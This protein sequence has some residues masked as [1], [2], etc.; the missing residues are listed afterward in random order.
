MIPNILDSNIILGIDLLPMSKSEEF[1]ALLFEVSNEDR[2]KI[3]C[4]LHEQKKRVSDISR[5]L[6]LTYTEIRRHISRLQKIDL[7][8]RDL[9]GFYQLTPYGETCLKLFDDFDFL[10]SHRDYFASHTAVN[11]P[12]RFLKRLSELSLYQFVDNFME[13]LNFIDEKIKESKEFVWL[14]IDRYPII[15]VDSLLDSVERGVKIRINEQSDLSGPSVAFE[16]KHLIALGSENPDVIIKVHDRKDVYLFISDAGSAISFPNEDGFDYSG[17]T[18]TDRESSNWGEDLFNLYWEN[19]Q[20]KM[21]VLLKQFTTVTKKKGKTITVTAKTDPVLNSHAIQN[22]VDNF[23]EV[24]LRGTFNLEDTGMRNAA[25]GTGTTVIKIRKSV[26]IRGEGREKDVPATKINKNTWKFPFVDLEYVFEVD[27]EDIDVTIENIHFQDFNCACVTASRGNSVKIC[28]NRITLPSGLGR[29]QSFPNIGNIITG[30]HIMNPISDKGQFPGGVLIE[31]N[32][33]DFALNYI[34][35][36]YLPRTKLLDPEYRPDLEKHESYLG[37]GILIHN[38]LGKVVISNN[39]VRN[40]NTR[41]IV[42]Q[43]NYESSSI[44]ITGNT[45]SSEIFGS[46][47]YSTHFAG[48]GIQAVSAFE[49]ARSGS[50]VYISDNDIRCSKLNYCSIAVYGPSNYKDLSGKLGEC[51]INNNRIHL[52][53]GSVGIVIRKNDD[54]EVYD[55]RISGSVYY[56]F[57]LWGSKEREGFDLGSNDNSIRDNDLSSLIIKDSDE[58]SDRHVDGRMFTG[59]DGNSKTAHVWL[60]KYSNRNK[61]QIRDDEV[62]IDEGIDNEIIREN[63]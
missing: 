57:Q 50:N 53:D 43:D 2:D 58:Y 45:I 35:G 9:D 51:I 5:E 23:D 10:S 18:V 48:I 37:Y 61:I 28:N 32:Y 14:C 59:S 36:G 46:Y 55:N 6:D 52:E 22:A 13:F 62:V 54:V 12:L 31:G 19:A 41:G 33:L 42:L 44:H 16:D 25:M 8:R 38:I 21:P 11:I 60:N 34:A 49:E 27:G 30:I 63:N 40:M 47:P 15:A 4:T 3:L 1:Y 24:I 39:V 17:F 29:G 7:I 26:V 20:P 56:G